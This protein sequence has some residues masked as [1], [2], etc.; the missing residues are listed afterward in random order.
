M[1]CFFGHKFGKWE[2]Y[3]ASCS[4]Y[5]HFTGTKSPNF[6][7]RKQK[8]T[9]EKCGFTQDEKIKNRYGGDE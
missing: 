6:K 7:I 8:R 3:E 1:S 2:Q 4:R 9:C 5:N